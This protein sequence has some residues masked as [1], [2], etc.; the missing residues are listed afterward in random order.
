MLAAPSALAQVELAGFAAEHLLTRR[1]P[2]QLD[3]EVGFAILTRDDRE[4]RR[5][6]EGSDESDGYRAVREVL[7]IAALR[8][9]DE[10]EREVDRFYDAARESLAAVWPAVRRVAEALLKVEELDRDG[11]FGAIGARDIYAA[12]LNVQEAHGFRSSGRGRHLVSPG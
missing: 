3:R 2:R 4:L 12:V 1:R 6:F 5:A 11:V 8:T 7:R 9:N 10:L